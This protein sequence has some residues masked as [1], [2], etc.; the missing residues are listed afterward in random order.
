MNGK[1]K[2]TKAKSRKSSTVSKAV[3]SYVDKKLSNDGELYIGNPQSL[4]QDL[5]TYD[6]NLFTLPTFIDVTAS[7][8]SITQG[9]GQG[10]RAGNRITLKHLMFR[11]IFRNPGPVGA[12]GQPNG[13]FKLLFA[14]LKDGLAPPV[15]A[16]IQQL[17]QN[18]NTA[19]PPS[20]ELTQIFSP[21]NRDLFDIKK[22][23]VIKL[24]AWT[25]VPP[26]SD[27]SSNIPANGAGMYYQFS[28]DLVKHVPKT[29]IYN[30][31]ATQP[32]NQGL[33]LFIMG[34]RGLF[35]TTTPLAIRLDGSITPYY[36]DK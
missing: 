8:D 33:Y 12:A 2:T 22:T 7:L 1:K 31:T 9:T 18:G 16:D 15:L 6:P 13:V 25:E 28:Y 10:N 35:S 30:D 3:K 14:K 20:N 24:N 5:S 29:V 23:K 27:T 11:G 21:L 4:A 19:V 17:V 32:T 36:Y 34:A 26:A